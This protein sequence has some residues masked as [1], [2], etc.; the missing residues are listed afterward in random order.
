MEMKDITRLELNTSWVA[1]LFVQVNTQVLANVCWLL[2][3]SKKKVSGQSS[4]LSE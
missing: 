4:L 3:V 1:Y 2:Y